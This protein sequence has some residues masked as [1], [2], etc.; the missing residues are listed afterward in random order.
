MTFWTIA[1]ILAD[2]KAKKEAQEEMKRV[3]QLPNNNNSTTN[4]DNNS[5]NN[6]GQSSPAFS[7]EQLKELVKIEAM[8]YEVLR[9][10]VYTMITRQVMEEDVTFQ[11]SGDDDEEGEG[12][13]GGGGEGESSQIY[14]LRKGDNVVI[15]GGYLHY[16]PEIYHN[17]DTFQYDR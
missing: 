1:Y 17:P 15:F 5:N 10:R 12:R 8:I 14:K 3:F 4:I 9:L 6:N 11:L 7:H 2:D 16:D 13:G